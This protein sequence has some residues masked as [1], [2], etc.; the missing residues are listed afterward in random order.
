[1]TGPW[2]HAGRRYKKPEV[3][4]RIPPVKFYLFYDASFAFIIA[5]C[6]DY[7]NRRPAE[8]EPGQ[9]AFESDPAP[10]S[11]NQFKFSLSDKL[12]EFSDL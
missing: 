10:F 9:I 4:Q 8:K 6:Q 2:Y 1:M 3:F 12:T 7:S 5:G 11:I